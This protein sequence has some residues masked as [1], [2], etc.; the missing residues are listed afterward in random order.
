MRT[1]LLSHVKQSIWNRKPI[2]RW[3]IF[4]HSGSPCCS[5]TKAP[6]HWSHLSSGL[7]G[8]FQTIYW[9]PDKSVIIILGRDRSG[10]SSNRLFSGRA[11]ATT[12]HVSRR[13]VTSCVEITVVTRCP[14]KKSK[15]RQS[16]L[17]HWAYTETISAHSNVYCIIQMDAVHISRGQSLRSVKC[18]ANLTAFPQ[19]LTRV[20]SSRW[21][22]NAKLLIKIYQ[23][24]LN[25]PNK[26]KQA[27]GCR[28]WITRMINCENAW[29]L[30]K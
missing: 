13:L 19:K 2:D 3:V 11:S 26:L 30:W 14:Q 4:L 21:T 16:L 15:V 29:L 12:T 23:R 10:N 7:S 27:D 6:K 18:A 17:P 22:N 25:K 20:A 8:I 5:W 24:L 1:E 28:F 9:W